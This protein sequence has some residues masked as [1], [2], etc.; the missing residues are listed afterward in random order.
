MDSN[1]A[2]ERRGNCALDREYNILCS[3]AAATRKF[4]VNQVATPSSY[5]D[6]TEF[7]AFNDQR[8]AQ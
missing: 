2:R 4:K 5:S 1:N 8:T 7:T 3:V 6:R